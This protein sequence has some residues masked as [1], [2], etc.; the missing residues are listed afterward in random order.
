MRSGLLILAV[1]AASC[2]DSSLLGA[3]GDLRVDPQ[4]LDFPSAWEG[5]SATAAVTVTNAGRG[6]LEVALSVTPPFTVA[7]TLSLAGGAD[8]LVTI[9]LPASSAGDFTGVLSVSAGG[10]NIDVTLNAH[11]SAVPA[12]EASE[13]HVSTFDPALGECVEA[14]GREDEPCGAH[15]VCI[16]GAVCRNGSCMGALLNCDD[17]DACTTDSCDRGTGCRHDTVTCVEPANPCLAA[18]CDPSTGCGTTPVEDGVL[19]GANDCATA[20]VC[21][22]GACVTRPSPEG[23]QCAPAS[24]C[25]G[26]SSCVNSVCTPPAPSIQTPA[27]K[28]GPI[29]EHDLVFRGHVDNDGNAYLVDTYPRLDT[30]EID[31]LE[32]ELVSFTPNGLQRFRVSLASGC[33]GCR[34]GVEFAID[35]IGDRLF[36]VLR[37][38]LIARSLTDGHVLWHVPYADGVPVYDGRPDGGGAYSPSAP[39]LI[40]TNAVAV[41]VMEGLSDHHSYVRV[42]DRATG[43]LRWQ[44]HRKGHLYT[45]GV[46]GNGELWTSSANCWAPAGEVSRVAPTGLELGSHFYNWM[47]QSYGEDEAFGWDTNTGYPNSVD[48]TMASRDLSASL[49]ATRIYGTPL[50]LDS[51]I[52][53]KEQ[54]GTLRS[55]DLVTGPNFAITDPRTMTGMQLLRSGGVGWAGPATNG[56][57]GYV[58][59]VDPHGAQIYECP[60]SVP[61]DGPF[62]IVGGRLYANSDNNLVVFTTPGLDASPRGWSGERGSPEHSGRAR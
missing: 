40:G 4:H 46:T 21:I 53:F 20:H 26:T 23:S 29:A 24:G 12:C 61:V 52:V 49:G 14:P 19:C 13:C 57:G 3:Q 58:R 27:W 62:S 9:T 5:H 18:L 22:D 47:P 60:L 10:K 8:D 35:T 59:A 39:M 51:L 11:V 28:Y 34:Y 16:I 45:P 31:A 48:D 44:F 25:I 42:F 17:G 32:T 41:P 6:G 36:Y 33:T 43:A 56:G 37:D 54:D 1:L 15:N 7:P 38:E 50:V 55:V 30:G 2:R